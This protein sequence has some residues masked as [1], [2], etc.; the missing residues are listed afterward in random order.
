MKK[1]KFIVL[2]ILTFI[3][4]SC[5]EE[6]LKSEDIKSVEKQEEHFCT[7]MTTQNDNLTS[8]GG[9]ITSK[10]WP[11]KSII[12]I[13]FLNG[14]IYQQEKVKEFAKVWLQFVDLKF[15]FVNSNE[16]ASVKISFKWKNDQQIED[17]STWSNIGT[18]CK[19]IPQ[20]LPSMN[21]GWF[22]ANTTDA[23]YSTAVTHAFGHVLGLIDEQQQP[24]A[25]VIQWNKPVVYQ[26]FANL[27]TPW[28]QAQVDANIIEKYNSTQTN[29]SE[30]DQKSIMHYPIPTSWTLNGNSVSPNTQ[31]SF[32]DKYF[33]QLMYPLPNS[34][35]NLNRFYVNGVHLYTINYN[36]ISPK[37]FESV[38]GVVLKENTYGS[39]RIYRYYNKKTGDR[40]STINPN[41]I[42]PT[43]SNGWVYE[44]NSGYAY[45]TNQSDGST[46]PIYRYYNP[47]RGDHFF[48]DSY[49][50]LG[51]GKLGY[52][53]E[54]IAFYILWY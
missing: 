2:L 53:Y 22:D 8:R 6:K 32:F 27:A 41:E 49:N 37:Y 54:G 45:S 7:S 21:F 10:K 30:Y 36:E 52:A 23:E 17:L 31:L 51:S 46:K 9:I 50:E 47:S 16:F 39:V 5:N 20:D 28:T 19:L 26:Y 48:T 18:D 25:N 35:T 42:V 12:L 33:I 44:G 34:V 43:F 24:N 38:L 15:Q 3:F 4:W 13:K 14:D 11:K 40:L 29:F 1:T